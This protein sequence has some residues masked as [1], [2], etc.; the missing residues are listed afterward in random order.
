MHASPVAATPGMR[1]VSENTLKHVES[2]TDK[3]D[4]LFSAYQYNQLSFEHKLF[5]DEDIPKLRAKT[6]QSGPNKR[7]MS[8]NEK[9]MKEFD[10]LNFTVVAFEHLV[11]VYEAIK[12]HESPPLKSR[13]YTR[14][15]M[16]V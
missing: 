12:R 8:I 9:I 15:P 3:M 7:S 13:G 2:L 1:L 16:I 5:K 14:D 6:G 11:K 10:S 4:W